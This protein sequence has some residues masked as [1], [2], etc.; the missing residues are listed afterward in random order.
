MLIKQLRCFCYVVGELP[1]AR[2]I[3]NISKLEEECGVKNV[4]RLTILNWKYNMKLLAGS[5]H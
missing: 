1:L 4:R 5:S 3:N 2:H